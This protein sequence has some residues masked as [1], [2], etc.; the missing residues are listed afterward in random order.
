MWIQAN[1]EFQPGHRDYGAARLFHRLCCAHTFGQYAPPEGGPNGTELTAFPPG[2]HRM[3]QL[4]IGA[5]NDLRDILAVMGEVMQNHAA[6][7]LNQAIENIGKIF[8]P[9]FDANGLSEKTRKRRSKPWR[10][11][12]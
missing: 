6:N 10:T 7:N 1:F 3:E 4:N 8:K 2:L 11:P 5:N 12:K 9:K